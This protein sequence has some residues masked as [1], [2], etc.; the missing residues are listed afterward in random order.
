MSPMEVLFE[1]HF[2]RKTEGLVG[3]CEWVLCAC[4]CM[5]IYIY[6]CVCVCVCVCVSVRTARQMSLS[7]CGAG[8]SLVAG[9]WQCSDWADFTEDVRGNLKA[10][11]GLRCLSP[12]HTHTHSRVQIRMRPHTQ[13]HAPL[14]TFCGPPWTNTDVE[15]LGDTHTQACTLPPL[16]YYKVNYQNLPWVW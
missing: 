9:R 7:V 11:S 5:Y 12:P 3:M 8:L 16:L 6:V 15:T 14:Q 4:M 10:A 13:I 2:G 1:L